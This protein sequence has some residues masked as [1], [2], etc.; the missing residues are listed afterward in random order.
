MVR[1]P[2]AR[3]L[4]RRGFHIFQVALWIYAGVWLSVGWLVY[5]SKLY[6]LVKVVIAFALILLTPA[7]SDLFLS[8]DKYQDEHSR[9]Y[10]PS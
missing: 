8:Y 5:A 4:S 3:L 1:T 10:P 6:L 2:R 9:F 7:I